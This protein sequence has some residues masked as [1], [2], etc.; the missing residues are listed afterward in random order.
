MHASTLCQTLVH[1]LAEVRRGSDGLVEGTVMSPANGDEM[2]WILGT[3]ASRL[4]F[5][6]GA[7][8]PR[9]RAHGL[10]GTGVRVRAQTGWA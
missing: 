1:A 5:L 10:V 3:R 6:G 2:R 7:P 4:R 9:R 8:L